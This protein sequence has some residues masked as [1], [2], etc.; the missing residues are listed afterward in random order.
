MVKELKAS[1][2]DRVWAWAPAYES[3]DGFV[4]IVSP[5]K[6]E[7]DA[8]LPPVVSRTN[9]KAGFRG[10]NLWTGP[11]GH[12]LI[13][14]AEVAPGDRKYLH[15]HRFAETAWIV[16]EGEGEFYPDLETAVEIGPGVILH[17]YPWE[18]H[19]LGNTGDKPLR[20]ISVEGPRLQ[21][22]GTSYFAE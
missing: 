6:T 3:H 19:G 14:L 1:E 11:E 22:E 16:L 12:H 17:S 21:R 7:P 8:P 15:R 20:Y 10:L 13:Q 4:D 9:G 2:S 18:W 5:G